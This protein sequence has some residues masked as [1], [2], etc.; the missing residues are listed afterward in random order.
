MLGLRHK[1]LRRPGRFL[2]YK[3]RALGDELLG[4]PDSDDQKLVARTRRAL[5]GNGYLLRLSFPPSDSDTPRYGYGRA[6]HQRLTRL[7]SLENDRYAQVLRSFGAYSDDLL[8][9][10]LNETSAH[11]PHWRNGFLFGLDGVSLYG[12]TRTRAP[13]H[14]IEIGSGNS[15]LFV[16]RARRDGTLDTRITS[17]DPAPR[18]EVDAICDR[19]IRQPLERSDLDMFGELRE[20]DIVFMDGTHRVFMNSDSVGFFLDVLPYLPP[21]VL[22]GIHD[23]HLPDDYRPEYAK[24]YYAEQYLLAALLL[25][26][27]AR[28]RPV[29]PNW[30]VSHH[31]GLG[32]AAR[33]LLPE[34][35]AQ[36]PPP[37][38]G[39]PV[40]Q[41]LFGAIFWLST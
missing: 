12:F 34:A 10:P 23:V 37:R 38:P 26:E 14:Y 1:A 41:S 4:H 21:G 25:G 29:L 3:L 28:L 40:D 15:T 32:K 22:V 17:I 31:P 27:P 16:D 7:L 30:F 8:E 6:P 9:I 19:V 2:R 36:A 35:Y 20:G 18:R 5:F 39:A 13:R 24:R 33:A 11:E